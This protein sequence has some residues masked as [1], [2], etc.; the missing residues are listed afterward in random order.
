MILINANAD[1]ISVSDFQF[2]YTNY[3]KTQAFT[4]CTPTAPSKANGKVVGGSCALALHEK[5]K[6]TILINSDPT[7]HCTFSQAK[8]HEEWQLI[9][10][11]HYNIHIQSLNKNEDIILPFSRFHKIN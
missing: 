5:K 11:K 10:I 6:K 2:L 7:S 9:H 8:L 3:V 4:I 1:L